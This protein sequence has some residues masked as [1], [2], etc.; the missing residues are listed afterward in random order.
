MERIELILGHLN[1]E[2]MLTAKQLTL[3]TAPNP[4]SL[5]HFLLSKETIPGLSGTTRL[6]N[7]WLDKIRKTVI[8]N[9]KPTFFHVPGVTAPNV[10]SWQ[11]E[12]ICANIYTTYFISG[13]LTAWGWEDKANFVQHGLKPDRR[14]IIDGK[15]IFWEADRGTETLSKIKEKVEKYIT[16]SKANP[17]QRFHV[18][19]A[20]EPGRVQTLL[21]SVLC[22][23]PRGDQFFVGDW[24]K[25][26]GEPFGQHLYSKNSVVT[27]ISISDIKS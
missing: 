11:H 22:D 2:K 4:E 10:F 7:R 27:P 25:I 21:N 8:D 5:R 26:V 16:Y 19:F 9:N 13:K 24:R 14:S 20:T 6:L 3:L 15:V 1:N 12:L 23:F 17:S 18:I